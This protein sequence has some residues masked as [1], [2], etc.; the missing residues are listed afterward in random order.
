MVPEARKI[1]RL[2]RLARLQARYHFEC[3]STRKA[4]SEVLHLFKFARH[5]G[6]APVVISFLLQ[7]LKTTKLNGAAIKFIGLSFIFFMFFHFLNHD[8]LALKNKAAYLKTY[9]NATNSTMVYKSLTKIFKDK[10]VIV[11][12]SRNYD[13]LKIMFHT[14][15]RARSGVPSKKNIDILRE[16]NIDIAVFDN[17]KLPTYILGDTTIAKIRSQVWQK[18]FGEDIEVYY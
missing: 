11:Y 6:S 1:G 16:N 12:N 2:A 4:V 18:N 13:K 8:S 7:F 17:N 10:E 5:V 14:G 9:Q 15:Y 3:G